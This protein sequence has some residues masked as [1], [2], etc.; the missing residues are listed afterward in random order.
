MNMGFLPIDVD[1]VA[2]I[3]VS[4]LKDSCTEYFASVFGASY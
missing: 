4:V 1:Y 3:Q 2:V